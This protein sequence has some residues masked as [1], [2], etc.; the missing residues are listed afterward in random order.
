MNIFV[1]INIITP[2]KAPAVTERP[3]AN[4][5]EPPKSLR[6][7]SIQAN[8]V[9]ASRKVIMTSIPNALTKETFSLTCVTPRFPRTSL[10]T[11]ILSVAEPKTAP[12]N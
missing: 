12:S 4:G 3:M 2:N 1:A 5:N 11:R 10:G 6:F 7:L 8:T 9:K